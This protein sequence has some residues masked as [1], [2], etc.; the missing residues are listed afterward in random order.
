MNYI[1]LF[2]PGKNGSRAFFL[3]LFF[4]YISSCGNS[5]PEAPP[6]KR[7]LVLPVE[8]GKVIY[9]DVV[10]SVRTVGNLQA[11]QRV[12]LASEI[13]GTLIKVPV[14]E[15]QR[16]RAGSVLAVVD[17][18]EYELEV[19]RLQAELQIAQ[20][21]Y[22]K[23]LEGLRPEEQERLEAQ[24]KA[25]ESA[26]NLATKEFQRTEK[27]VAEGVL[28]VSLLD[29]AQDKIQRAQE[30][31]KA[32]E[33]AL[34]AGQRGRDED[35]LQKKSDLDAA[36]KRLEMA[37][38]NLSKTRIAAPFSGIVVIKL[39]EKGAYVTSG[40]PLFEM[41]GSSKL[42]AVVELP[43][44]YRG[45]LKRVKS[46]KLIIPEINLEFIQKRN[47]S[48]K[49]RVIP[50]ANI[51]S[52]NISVQIDIDK[53]SRALFPGLT[54]EAVFEFD[55]RKQV[56]HVPSISLVIGEKGTVVYLMQK[57]KA[58]LVP[59]KAFKERDDYVEIEDFTH[60]LNAE[61]QIIMRGS[62]AIFPGANVFPTNLGEK[63]GTGK[64]GKGKPSKGKPAPAKPGKGQPP[65]GKP[66]DKQGKA[67]KANETH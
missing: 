18:S 40:T 30:T 8:I 9:R 41:I 64:P 31:L 60:Q 4:F 51:F 46:V 43:Q 13:N 19:E 42:K 33:A 27:L 11:E 44:S 38:L 66:G 57:G 59:V 25:D 29:E 65:Q 63:P 20:Q 34:V 53:P 54:L 39:I 48:R 14:R 12:T 16:V 52:G 36:Q 55:T 22:Q 62:G 23:A 28:A 45:K 6:K 61:S 47:L 10:D 21:E 7:E 32:S 2:R 50:D 15:G 5:E 26:L 56:P 58:Q 49:I 67:T 24:V 3:A 35:I 37:E 17:P 1:K